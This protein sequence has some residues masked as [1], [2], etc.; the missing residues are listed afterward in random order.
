MRT[1]VIDWDTDIGTLL[2]Y[3]F[4]N[5]ENFMYQPFLTHGTILMF[6]DT[7]LFHYLTTDTVWDG[8]MIS[9]GG[10]FSLN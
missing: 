7:C 10:I 4:P 3:R 2:Y 5:I 9:V 8:L 6:P 1:E